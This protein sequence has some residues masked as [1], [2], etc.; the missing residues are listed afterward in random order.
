MDYITCGSKLAAA[1]R[2]IAGLTTVSMGQVQSKDIP[3]PDDWYN[4][5]QIVLN[6]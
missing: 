4:V 3:L 6:K 1:T 5:F 2:S